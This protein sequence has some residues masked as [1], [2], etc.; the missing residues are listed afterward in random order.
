M[1]TKE[2]AK[3]N[4]IAFWTKLENQLSKKR[5]AHGSKIDWMSYPTGVKHLYFRM[6]A[7]EE[8]VKLVIDMQFPDDGVREVYY[9]QFQE[10][11][12][13]LESEF[14]SL[15]WIKE[16]EHWNGKTISRIS[17]EKNEVNINRQSDW[18]KMHLFLKLNFVK[19]DNFWNEYGEVFRLLK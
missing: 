1:W 5:N 14:K 9:E 3:E 18:D 16:H 11:Q 15:E 17:M 8:S 7:N 4:K 10:F 12:N 13:I 2:E 19:L 6:E